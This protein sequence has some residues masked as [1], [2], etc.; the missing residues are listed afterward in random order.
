MTTL[1][2]YRKHKKGEIGR[3]RFLYEVR[4]DNNLPWVTNTTSYDDA[5]KILKNKG[6]IREAQFEPQNIPTDPLVDRVN[7]YALK[8]EVEKLL[9]KETELTNDSYKR[10]LNKAAKKLT[11]PEAV[12]QAMFA[13]ADSVAKADAKLQTQAVK[14]NNLKDKANEM[15]KAKG[16]A[17]PK[18]TAAPTKE[19]KKTKKPKGVEIMKDKGVEGSEKVLRETALAELQSFL[20]K[21]LNLSEDVHYEYHVGSEVHLPE[22]GTG[23][24]IEITG[25]TCTVEVADGTHK[26][27]QMN[28]LSHAKKNAMEATEH[29]AMAEKKGDYESGIKLANKLVDA[30]EMYNALSDEQKEAEAKRLG[31][32][33]L[34]KLKAAHDDIM[35]RIHDESNYPA[36]EEDNLDE[37][38]DFNDPALVASR[39]RIEKHRTTPKQSLAKYLD[40][41]NKDFEILQ[42]I[43]DLKRQRAQVMRDME[44]EAEPEGGPI[45]DDY[46]D[47]LMDLDQ[48]I[49]AL[50]AQL[51]IHEEELDEDSAKTATLRKA[52][53]QARLQYL[54]S[55]ADDIKKGL[56]TP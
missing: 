40:D 3:D 2:L 49:K 33:V 24:I 17:M 28:V 6:I 5:V 36:Q 39:A 46:A 29:P 35:N 56:Q 14:K 9:A 38:R 1:E 54:Q 7:P 48:Q 51:S 50:E 16:Q 43:K 42:Q 55:Q 26:D 10:A 34:A 53:D 21:K 52:A 23:K 20:K 15:K 44:Q 31:V 11:T 41:K 25:G 13:N 22:G 47:R 45:A 4:R 18:T 37:A 8:R 12:K 32:D 27:Y 19:N 30:I